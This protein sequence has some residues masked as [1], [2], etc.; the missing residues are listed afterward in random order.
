MRKKYQER[1]LGY[2]AQDVKKIFPDVV[3]KTT[4][5]SYFTIKREDLTTYFHLGVQE[6][7]KQNKDQKTQIET[8]LLEVDTLKREKIDL[9]E[10]LVKI[11]QIL[12][13]SYN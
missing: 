6:L 8:I 2:I 5:D 1:H 9:L 12:F 11:E 4:E 3:E 7:I 13:Y 10:R